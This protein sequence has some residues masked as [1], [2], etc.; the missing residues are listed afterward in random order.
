[1]RRTKRKRLKKEARDRAVQVRRDDLDVKKRYV[2][3]KYGFD[4]EAFDAAFKKLCDQGIYTLY[5]N[6]KIEQ[7]IKVLLD[8]RLVA[9]KKG[10]E[11]GQS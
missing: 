5:G 6:L 3:N 10:D 1:M 11:H 8:S 7:L 4:R 9:R 2:V